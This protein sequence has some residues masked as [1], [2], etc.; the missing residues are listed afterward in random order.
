MKLL[1]LGSGGREHAL[2]WKTAQSRLVQ[3]LYCAP[4]SDAITA[5]AECIPLDC[6]D[7][8][9]VAGFCAEKGVDLV[10][11]GPE[12]P[13]ASGVSD[14]LRRSGVRVFGPG[15]AAARLE[16]SKAFA[17]KFLARHRIPTAR[18]RTCATLEEAAAALEA[19]KPPLVIKAD[20][21]AAGKGVRICADR[22]EAEDTVEDFMRLKTLQAAGETVV[23]EE[24]LS[25]P[26]LSALALT[27]GKTCRLLPHSRDHKRLLDG[28][29]GPNTGGM[30]AFAP[31][32]T[33]PDLESAIR[34]IFESVLAG[35]RE[36]G[37]DYR[38][39]LYAGLMLTAQG[40]KVLEFNCRFG[41]PE[42]QALLPLLDC[43]L[44]ALCL[45]CAEGRL[46][47]AELKFRPGACVCVTLASENYP[48]APM[49][50]RPILGLEEFPA[51]ACGLGLCPRG[52]PAGAGRT[53][54][55]TAGA[56]L[57]LFH[58]GTARPGGKWTTAGGR[59]LGVTAWG[60]DAAAAR[61]RAYEGVS[62]ISFDGMHYRRDIA[63]ELLAIR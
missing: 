43:D 59:V 58:A 22:E 24:C 46:G 13:L 28:D 1:I 38:G 47:T 12:T 30:G 23:I 45:A 21:L 10:I 11:I 4:G 8:T 62:R 42:T 51:G 5:L 34:G 7:G 32:E 52:S 36:D 49:T 18:G 14:V 33:G 61:R 2:A 15:Q 29:K 16:S 55:P 40:P 20:G 48:R 63:G 31:V 44:A 57:M 26:E 6:C 53:D 25:G 27:D 9:E 56:D 54:F 37:L 50:G 41:D 3:K 35:L 17:K 39:L 60:P 19:M